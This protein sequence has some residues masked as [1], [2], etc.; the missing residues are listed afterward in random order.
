MKIFIPV[1]ISSRELMYKVYLCNVLASRGVECYLGSKANISYLSKK[2]KDF[3]YLDK[4]FHH[5]VSEKIYEILKENNASFVSLDEE[6][7]L[8]FNDG[9]VLRQR[10]TSRLFESA[11]AVFLWGQR[12][13]ENLIIDK[14][15]TVKCV[16][17]GHPR[18]QLLKPEYRCLFE[19]EKNKIEIKLK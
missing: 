4:G 8:D 14:I 19:E 16:I 12:Q 10:Y 5:G 3:I 15:D 1:E 13:F 9:S 17:S 6:G 7:A 2:S 18:F 11:E